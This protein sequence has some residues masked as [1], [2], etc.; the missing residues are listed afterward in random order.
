MNLKLHIRIL[1]GLLFLFLAQ[2]FYSCK[3]VDLERT[4]FVKTGQVANITA[5]SALVYGSIIDL[6]SNAV[7]EFGLAYSTSPEPTVNNQVALASGSAALGEYSV[8][9]TGLSANTQYFVRSYLKSGGSVVYATTSSSFTTQSVNPGNSWLHYDDGTNFDGI[10]LNAGGD[11][12]VAIRFA[13]SDIS[14]YNGWKITKIRFFP[15]IGSP[16]VYTLEIL[17]GADVPGLNYTQEV[18]SPIIDQWNEVTLSTP[19]TINASTDLWVGYW[20]QNQQAGTYPVGCDAGP[21][22]AGKGDM[23]SMDGLGSWYSLS[24]IAPSLNYNFNI[25]VYIVSQTGIEKQLLIEEKPVTK[26]IPATSGSYNS[27]SFGSFIQSSKK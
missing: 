21:A 16:I 26:R 12:D 25:Q 3:K 1:S 8:A 22:V 4:A 2:Q 27:N 23:I 11:F 10:G 14:A 15:K 9:I 20:V 18:P 5:T 13:P 19:F 7:T 24:T 6:G 17:T